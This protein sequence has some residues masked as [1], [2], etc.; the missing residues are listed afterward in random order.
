MKHAR[1]AAAALVL[2]G[3]LGVAGHAGARDQGGWQ[4]VRHRGTATNGSLGGFSEACDS[5]GQCVDA[6]NLIDVVL[7]GDDNGK[8]V[9]GISQVTS[10]TGVYAA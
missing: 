7:G 10:T 2:A 5:V 3:S 9:Q 1:I 8:A 6:L 4:I